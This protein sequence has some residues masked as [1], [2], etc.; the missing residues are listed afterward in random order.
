[1]KRHSP[2]QSIH[3][4]FAEAVSAAFHA[5]ADIERPGAARG[6][7]TGVFQI[8]YLPYGPSEAD[9]IT[10]DIPAAFAP[11][12]LEYAA[13]RRGAAVFDAPHRGVLRIEGADRR[14]FLNSMVTQE[15]KD[16]APGVARRTFWLNRKGRIEADLMIMEFGE[17]MLVD[18]DWHQA[19]RVA[20]TLN[21]FLF[22][23]DVVI[24]DASDVWHTMEVHGPGALRVLA[25]AS[26]DEH[27][28]IEPGAC[29]LVPIEAVEVAVAR[30]DDLG[31][32]GLRLLMPREA[33]ERVWR[34]LLR[35]DVGS[36]TEKR[37][38]RPVGW[39]ACNIARVEAGTPLFNI[40]YGCEN[41]PHETGLLHERVSFTKGCY[42]GQ[43]IV[44]RTEHLG[45]PKQ[46]LVGLRTESS[47]LPVAGDSVFAAGEVEAG[48]EIGVVTSST[49]SPMLGSA[50]I[51][52]AMLRTDHATLG[53]ELMVTAEG[54]TTTAVVCDLRFLPESAGSEGGVS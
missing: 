53:T 19:P 49:L 2:L 12:E 47:T 28:I 44:A 4:E 52:F 32:M 46:Q 23:E 40:D 41:L 30:I 48:A 29:G 25:E 50:S 7:R 38:V 21:Q 6:E 9:G 1:M 14:D 33:A 39:Y 27:I 54:A 13:I 43:E 31:V 10:V 3:A 26:G 18:V 11:I 37:R 51:A 36:S 35:T 45:K 17:R 8:D 5:L 42:L 20:K 22:S 15:L 16:L 24:E 34:R